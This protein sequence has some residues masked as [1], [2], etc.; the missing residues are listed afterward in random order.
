MTL[1]PVQIIAIGLEND[2]ERGDVARE[3]WTASDQG[4]IRVLDL[5]AIRKEQDGSII[6]LGA[7]DL[8]PDERMEFGAVLGGLLGLGAAGEEGAEIGAVAG[9]EAF[10]ERTFGLSDDDIQD[11]ARDIPSGKTAVMMLLEHRWAVPLKEAIQRTGG[12]V[13]GQGMVQPESLV[14]AG[15]ALAAAADRVTG[16]SIADTGA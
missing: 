2:K 7:T 5:L 4:T 11:L 13:L 3:L 6:S 16:E 12:V 9:A 8:S 10:S 15:A 1:G 14:L